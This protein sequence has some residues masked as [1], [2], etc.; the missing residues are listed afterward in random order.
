VKLKPKKLYYKLHSIGIL[1]LIIL[2]V[3]LNFYISK[4]KVNSLLFIN[5]LN[6]PIADT[7]FKYITYLGDGVCWILILIVSYF[8]A[9]K[10]IWIVVTNFILSTLFAQGLKR[11]FFYNELRPSALLELGYQLHFVD[12]VKM[13]L[14]HSFP[15][16]HTTTAFAIAFTTILLLNR[17][18][19]M[20][21]LLVVIALIVAYSRVYLAQH[22]VLDVIVGAFLGVLSTFL[23]IYVLSLF[24]ISKSVVIEYEKA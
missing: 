1:T 5:Q 15:S 20:K 11:L 18:N 23:S 6:H 22:Y 2:L 16:G 17:K 13:Y 21:Y 12:G 4:G 10:K 14:H 19:K 24:K 9:K 3:F 8:I 7:F